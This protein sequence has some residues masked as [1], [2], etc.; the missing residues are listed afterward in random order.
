[1]GSWVEK[2]VDLMDEMWVAKMDD[3]K[4][5]HLAGM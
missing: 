1:M 3:L 5:V 4:D 2:L